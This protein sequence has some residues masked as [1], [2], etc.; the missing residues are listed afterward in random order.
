MVS[1]ERSKLVERMA[2]AMREAYA[3][4]TGELPLVPFAKSRAREEWLACAEAG[5]KIAEKEYR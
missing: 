4:M 1:G 3:E 2:I 5:L